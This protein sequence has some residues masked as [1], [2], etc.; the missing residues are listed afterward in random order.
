M[1]FWFTRRMAS[2]L[3]QLQKVM[4]R[5]GKGDYSARYIE[6]RRGYEINAIGETLNETIVELLE[7]MEAVKNERVE[8]ETLAKELNIGRNIQLS[9][10]PQEMPV[11]P[12]VDIAAGTK[13]AKEV[14]GDFFDFYVH[15]PVEDPENPKLAVTIA[16]AAGKG[17]SACLYSLCLRS[18]LRSY[19]A[20]YQ[21]VGKI[22]HLANNLF[23]Q[24]TEESSMFV[25]VFLGLFDS[26]TGE[27]D[28][29]SAGHHPVILRRG[30]GTIEKL[31]TGHIAMG[32]IQ[33][34]ELTHKKATLRAGDLLI[35]YTDGVTEALS[36]NEKLY[37]EKRL[38]DVIE[39]NANQTVAT[40]WNAIIEDIENFSAGAPQHDDITLIVMR[41]M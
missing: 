37:G 8:K 35:F 39:H 7:H 21:D 3:Q 13:P 41:I 29:L 17:I 36:V 32:V 15:T 11:Y 14:C 28:Y 20:E 22:I 10:L 16:D 24:D 27:F 38:I 12:A 26:E 19:V 9:I 40:I 25:T 6:D 18:M 31:E 4:Q 1:T 2:P 34:E 33:L 23:Y 5:V 30:D